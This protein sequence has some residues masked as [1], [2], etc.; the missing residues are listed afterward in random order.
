MRSFVTPAILALMV[1]FGASAADAATIT[2]RIDH[3]Y[4]HQRRIVVDNH[5]YRM[6]PHTFRT[7][8]MQRGERAHVTY[9]WSGGHR[10]ATK[11][12]RA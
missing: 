6:T 5:V 12:T 11:V 4:P 3:V 8:T 10:W 7:T 1:G 2:G 9:H